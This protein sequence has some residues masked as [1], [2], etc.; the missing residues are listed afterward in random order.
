M[1]PPESLSTAAA[2]FFA[3]WCCVSLS[4]GNV[5]FIT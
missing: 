2:K 3:I 4:V 5:I 1:R